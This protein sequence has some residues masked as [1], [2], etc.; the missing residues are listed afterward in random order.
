M[1]G[2]DVSKVRHLQTTKL[3]LIETFILFCKTSFLLA[4]PCREGKSMDIGPTDPDAL[5]TRPCRA[6]VI[7]HLPARTESVLF[8][9]AAD[10]L[11]HLPLHRITKIAQ[12]IQ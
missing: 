7:I 10:S 9:A 4:T 6:D 8:I 2:I 11:D 5:E 12:A 3:A 1:R